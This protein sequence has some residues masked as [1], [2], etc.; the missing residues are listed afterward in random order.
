MVFIFKMFNTLYE[1]LA[2]MLGVIVTSFISISI[3]WYF[4]A[5]RYRKRFGGSWLEA[6]LATD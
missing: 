3:S 4:A 1:Y 2:F 5:K 6:L